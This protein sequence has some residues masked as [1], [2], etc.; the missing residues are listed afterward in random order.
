MSI[1]FKDIKNY[2]LLFWW[3]DQYKKS[4]SKQNQDRK[5]SHKNVLIYYIVYVTIK[6]LRY[7]KS[8]S[9]N[10]LYLIID[11]ING[12]I[13]E[14]NGNKYLT[15]IPTGESKDTQKKYEKLWDKIRDLIRSITDNSNN[16]D[17]KYV[18]TKI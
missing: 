18:K 2:R 10:P 3:H 14:S 17:E 15:L 13:K 8:N 6:D 11:K 9:V 1:K 16:Y 12:Y 7:V 4:Q 5:K